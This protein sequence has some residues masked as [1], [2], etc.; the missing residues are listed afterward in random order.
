MP[1]MLSASLE[2]AMFESLL[3][4][5]HSTVGSRKGGVAVHRWPGAFKCSPGRLKAGGAALADFF[6][7]YIHDLLGNFGVLPGIND[8]FPHTRQSSLHLWS[9]EPAGPAHW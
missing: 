5:G 8:G 2:L 6:T 1:V 4:V 9:H 3:A 7:L